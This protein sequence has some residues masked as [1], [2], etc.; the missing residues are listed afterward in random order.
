MKD[1]LSHLHEQDT[2]ELTEAKRKGKETKGHE[3][4]R[5]MVALLQ[6]SLPP[7]KR[8]KVTFTTAG[9][10]ST[11]ADIRVIHQDYPNQPLLIECKNGVSQGGA[12][13]WNYDGSEWSVSP[14]AK[15]KSICDSDPVYCETMAKTLKTPTVMNRV[16]KVLARHAHFIPELMTNKVSFNTV[17]EVWKIVLKLV[18][19]EIQAESYDD[20]SIKWRFPVEGDRYWNT[21]NSMMHQS[22]MLVIKGMGTM[23]VGGA[24]FPESWFMPTPTMLTAPRIDMVTADAGGMAEARFKRGGNEKTSIVQMNRR[25][26]IVSGAGGQH[27]TPPKDGDEI[28]VLGLEKA[29]GFDPKEAPQF[30]LRGGSTAMVRYVVHNAGD[31]DKDH[32]GKIVKIHSVTKASRKLGGL[33]QIGYEILCDFNHSAKTVTFETNLRLDNI[34][35]PTPVNFETKPSIFANCIV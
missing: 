3:F 32:I 9:L 5:E 4:Q 16:N 11:S 31:A 14:K 23:L 8:E 18:A 1:F 24:R 20:E 28:K 12:L 34:K 35:V 25:M 7:S 30:G 22:H 6:S 26:F 29:I 21:L 17:N 13:T 19:N 33:S 15:N 27:G 2:Q 10:G